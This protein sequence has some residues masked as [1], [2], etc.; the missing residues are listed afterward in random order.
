MQ[1]TGAYLRSWIQACYNS[2][3]HPLPFRDLAATDR[4]KNSASR[5]QARNDI[6]MDGGEGWSPIAKSL[7]VARLIGKLPKWGT[8]VV[9]VK[10]RIIRVNQ[11]IILAEGRV[12]EVERVRAARLIEVSPELDALLKLASAGR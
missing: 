1:S 8:V 11:S 12:A 3:K 6:C 5:I 7:F 10:F 9:A 4:R 2:T